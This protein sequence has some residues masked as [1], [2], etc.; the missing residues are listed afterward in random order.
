MLVAGEEGDEL[1]EPEASGLSTKH[2]TSVDYPR[3]RHCEPA[4]RCT[5]PGYSC[6]GAKTTR[7]VVLLVNNQRSRLPSLPQEE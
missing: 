7:I 5:L 2:G 4:P 6:V 3:Q 1:R